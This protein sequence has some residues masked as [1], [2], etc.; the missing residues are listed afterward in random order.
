MLANIYLAKHENRRYPRS[1]NESVSPDSE[2]M[3]RRGNRYCAR[4][5][6]HGSA[7]SSWGAKR[8]SKAR[9]VEREAGCRTRVFRTTSFRGTRSLGVSYALTS[10]H[11]HA[12]LVL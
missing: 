9:H 2:S 10:R 7:G 3:F 4:K 11:A 5:R 12:A 6:T 1:Q 8:P